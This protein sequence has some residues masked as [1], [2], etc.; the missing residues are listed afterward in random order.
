MMGENTIDMWKFCK[1][2]EIA[3]VAKIAKD[4]IGHSF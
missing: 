1:D 2:N 3:D 4:P